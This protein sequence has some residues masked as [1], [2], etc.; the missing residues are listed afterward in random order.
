MRQRVGIADFSGLTD[1]ATSG[2]YR[3]DPAGRNSVMMSKARRNFSF[4][5]WYVDRAASNSNSAVPLS[6]PE[7]ERTQEAVMFLIILLAEDDPTLRKFVVAS[8]E[9]ENFIVF[10]ASNGAEALQVCRNIVKV[11]LL[12]TDVCLG[13]SL[14]GI[15]LAER[16][17]KEKP[18]TKVL[19]MSGFPEIEIEAAGKV[20]A[21]LRK[22]FTH[23]DLTERVRKVLENSGSIGNEN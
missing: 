18:G 12:L 8:L 21:F 2:L 9:R 13:D 5:F 11:D 19:V 10:A 1:R 15:E 7:T 6:I 20:F 14:N 22:P 16:V 17:M 23:E 4:A 3:T